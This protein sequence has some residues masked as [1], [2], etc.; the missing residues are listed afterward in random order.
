MR[1]IIIISLFLISCSDEHGNNEE[2]KSQETDNLEL[3]DSAELYSFFL[4]K[5]TKCFD[6]NPLDDSIIFEYDN[7]GLP[8]QATEY[9]TSNDFRY[10]KF[11]AKR[12]YQYNVLDSTE[13]VRHIGINGGLNLTEIRK[14]D[15]EGKLIW[16]EK[17]DMNRD[18]IRY[19]FKYNKSGNLIETLEID[20]NFGDTLSIIE[21]W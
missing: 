14:F 12:E 13:T 10:G 1:L 18:Q 21:S 8:T 19:Y 17:T 11:C 6:D 15:P 4:D 2:S 5:T 7:F 16:L 20:W 9:Y 3:S